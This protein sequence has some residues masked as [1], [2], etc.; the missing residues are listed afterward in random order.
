M[1]EPHENEVNI[2]PK[3]NIIEKHEESKRY[4]HLRLNRNQ[5]HIDACKIKQNPIKR[6][7]QI[8]THH[9]CISEAGIQ[10]LNKKANIPTNTGM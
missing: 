6:A 5:K 3:S 10:R 8:P 7:L 4:F 9:N 2:N 1:L